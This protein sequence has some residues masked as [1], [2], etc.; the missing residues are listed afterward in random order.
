[1]DEED[2][3]ASEQE[4]L[5]DILEETREL[6]REN[7]KILRR[8]QRG[9]RVRKVISVLYILFILGTLL[10]TY[11]YLQPYIDNLANIYNVGT[12]DASST[13]AALESLIQ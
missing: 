13:R 11:Y 3:Q 8:L 6:S 2:R 5:Q 10:F 4:T 12:S 1:M 9:A 7:N